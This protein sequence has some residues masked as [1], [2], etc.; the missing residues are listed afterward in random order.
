MRE[1]IFLSPARRVFD[2][3]T[4]DE[5]R[6]FDNIIEV[7]CANPGLDLPLKDRFIVPPAVISLYH[8]GERWVVYDLP[9]DATVRIWM[10]GRVPAEPR[11]Y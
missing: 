2:G 7:I 4:A 1:H 3:A 11:P 9:D 8:D 5:Q 10:I 6:R